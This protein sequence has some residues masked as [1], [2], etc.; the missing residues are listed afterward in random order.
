MTHRK[1]T[2]LYLTADQRAR[3][4]ALAQRL[5]RPRMRVIREAID[6]I[7]KRYEAREVRRGNR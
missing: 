7:L 2:I 5:D 3:L 4:D 1:A 6:A